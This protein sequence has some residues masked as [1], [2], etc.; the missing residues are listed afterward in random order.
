MK[1]FYQ[2]NNNRISP[3]KMLQYTITRDNKFSLQILLTSL[4]DVI[5]NL[6]I[7]KLYNYSE[8]KQ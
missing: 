2:N 5:K 7:S 3:C 8:Y 6:N 1:Y 4:I